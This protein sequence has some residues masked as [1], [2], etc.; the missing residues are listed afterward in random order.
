M[1]EKETL[2]RLVD[3][4]ALDR[5][6]GPRGRLEVEVPAEVL[7]GGSQIELAVPARIVCARCE[8]GGCDGCGRSGA[9]KAPEDPEARRIRLTLPAGGAAEVDVRL[10]KPFGEDAAVEQ[11]LIHVKA[12]AVPSAGLVVIP[13]APLALH[14]GARRAPAVVFTAALVLALLVLLLVLAK[15]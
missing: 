3:P 11:L 13:P 1:S 7:A 5:A 2:G 6:T 14:P 8:G 15:R 9:L 4:E 10:V 12:G